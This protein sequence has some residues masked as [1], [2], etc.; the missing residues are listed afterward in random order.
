MKVW[1]PASTVLWEPNATGNVSAVAYVTVRA[2]H[3]SVYVHPA[4]CRGNGRLCLQIQSEHM[5]SRGAELPGTPQQVVTL[6]RVLILDCA[7]MW[8]QVRAQH[9]SLPWVLHS[10]EIQWLAH[11]N[12]IFLTVC[13]SNRRT[14][15]GPGLWWNQ[16]WSSK[17]PVSALPRVLHWNLYQFNLGKRKLF[18]LKSYLDSVPALAPLLSLRSLQSQA[19]YSSASLHL[20]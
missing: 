15:G 14:K 4:G 8:V 3:P 2:T 16:C 20:K 11:P 10:A 12:K 6:T 18:L 19:T 13:D 7:T 9:A 5:L 1:L 17:M